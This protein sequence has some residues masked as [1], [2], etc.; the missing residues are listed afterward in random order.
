ML[1]ACQ[2]S[3][4]R[5]QAVSGAARL[6]SWTHSGW[7]LVHGPEQ[8]VEGA[9]AVASLVYSAGPWNCKPIERAIPAAT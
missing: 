9:A 8:G 2:I 1:Q 6:R 4:G 7:K 5:L 3:H